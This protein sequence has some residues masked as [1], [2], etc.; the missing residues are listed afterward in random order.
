MFYLVDVLNFKL[1]GNVRIKKI[2]LILGFVISLCS[3]LAKFACPMP[4]RSAHPMSVRYVHLKAW[5]D[6]A[7]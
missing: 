2:V 5:L 4:A 7:S 3:R 1:N 6:L